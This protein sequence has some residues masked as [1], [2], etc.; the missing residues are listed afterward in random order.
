MHG[1]SSSTITDL[2]TTMSIAIAVDDDERHRLQRPTFL[3]KRWVGWAAPSSSCESARRHGAPS[4]RAPCG[5]RAVGAGVLATPTARSCL[6][7]PHVGPAA[8]ARHCVLQH[9]DLWL[10]LPGP[11][12][13]LPGQQLPALPVGHHGRVLPLC[14]L[15]AHSM[16]ASDAAAAPA[17]PSAAVV[18]PPREQNA[19]TV[20]PYDQCL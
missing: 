18:W 7:R 2:L 19:R 5:R 16:L 8:A 9:K 4:R 13:C 14:E 12:L 11:L 3:L 6:L 10:R 1:G 20:L 17:I 15:G